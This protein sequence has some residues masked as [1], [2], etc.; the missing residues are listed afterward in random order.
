MIIRFDASY[1]DNKTNIKKAENRRIELFRSIR[2][3]ILP[4]RKHIM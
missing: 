4:R 3:E 1:W 2:Q